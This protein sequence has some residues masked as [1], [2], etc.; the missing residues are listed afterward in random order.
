MKTQN[1]KLNKF[2]ILLFICFII[3]INSLAKIYQRLISENTESQK[4][5]SLEDEN[6]IIIASDIGHQKAEV[7]KLTKDGRVIYNN[8]T[9]SVGYTDDANLIQP[10][11]SNIYILTHHNKQNIAGQSSKEKIYSFKD[12]NTPIKTYEKQNSIYK[13][14]SSVSL[15]NGNIIVAG[16]KPKSTYGADTTS[17][18]D[19]YDPNTL[20]SG[21]GFSF[22][23]QS[24]YI[25]CYEQSEN[26]VYCVYVSYE[27]VF[28][29]KL[30]IKHILVNG[31][32]LTD[33]GDQV[34]KDFYTDFNFLKA[35]PFNE[36]ESVVL[37]QTGN[38][39]KKL[40][41]EGTRLFY[42][43]L[44]VESSPFLVTIKRYEYLFHDCL[45][46]ADPE[47][48]N[49]D[50][51]VLSKNRI[52]AACE[53]QN[54]KFR[55]FI[56]YPDRPGK[57]EI[58]EF[59][60]ENFSAA[61]VKTP[62]FAKFGQS[63]GI[64]YTQV[65]EN[66]NKKV[67]YH[68]MNYPD[69]DDYQLNPI[70]LPKGFSREIDFTGY[71]MLTNAYPKDR[72]NEEVKIRFKS[73][74]NMTVTTLDG[75]AM[76]AGTDY[77]PSLFLRFKTTQR[78]GK[79]EIEYTATRQDIYDGLIIGKTCK[80]TFNTPICLP[81]CESCTEKGTAEHHYCL[82]CNE[83]GAYYEDEDPI[84]AEA[85]L[86]KPY[87]FGK[88]HNCLACNVSCS[89]CWGPFYLDPKP[90][91]TNCKKCN[92]AE[93]Y[94]HYE[95]DER[96][97]IS[98][99]TKKYWE[100]I[101]GSAI[102]LDKS[103][104]ED[105]K[106]KWRWRHCHPN[107]DEC[108]EKG[109]NNDNKCWR[110]K[111]GLFFFCN[112]TIGNGIPGSCHS[113]CVNN[114]F[115]KTIKEDR[116]KCCPC[117]ENCKECKNE[118]I[119]DK[120]Y[121]PFLLT[122]EHDHCNLTC[123]YCYA[124]DRNLGECVNCKTRYQTP[125]YTLNKTCVDEIPFIEE[126]KR[127]H[128]ILDEKCNYLI[129]CKEGC[130]NCTP[131]YSDNCTQCNK[132]YY[133]EDFY[134]KT[135]QPEGFRCFNKTTCQGVTKYKHNEALRIG[136]VPVEENKLKV[137]LN[138]KLRND[139]YRLPENDFYCSDIKID[140]TYIDIEEYN[141]LSYCYFRCK[142]CQFWGNKYI[143]N[144]T[145]CRDG[146]YY[147][148]IKVK[149]S[150]GSIE[151]GNCYRKKHKCGIY[152]YYH[153]YDL[154]EKIGKDE[155]KCGEDCDV[156]LYNFTCVDQFPFFVYE[157]HE[158]VEYCDLTD[159]LG[160]VCQV[161]QRAGQILLINP[162]GTKDSFD[163]INS[164]VDI[165]KIIS[166][167]I[168]IYFL[169]SYDIEKN[170][171]IKDINNY[172]GNGQIYNLKESKIIV[173]NNISIELS[174]VRLEL[175]KINQ[176]LSGDTSVNQNISLVD[177]SDCQ[178]ILKSKYG[179]PSAEDL[180]LIKGDFLEKI[181][182]QYFGS[183]LYY[184]LFSTSIGA[185]LPL[186]EC[187]ENEVSALIK[188]FLNSSN[189][190]GDLQFKTSPIVD[191]GYNPFDP[192]SDFY[193]NP[194]TPFTNEDGNDVL[195]VDRSDYYNEN[196]H[197]CKDGCQFAGYNE[198]YKWFTCKCPISTDSDSG[199]QKYEEEKMPIPEGF[200]NKKSSYS[201]I[202]VFKC[203]SQA[204]SVK[205]IAKN[206]GFYCLLL[207]FISFI[208]I[209]VFYFVKDSKTLPII[210][211][212]L[213]KISQN[214]A[215]PPK[216]KDKEQ[217]EQKAG[218]DMLVK[219]PEKPYNKEVDLTYKEDEL[220]SV[221]FKIAQVQDKRSFWKYYWSLLK[222]KQLLIF[223]FYTY[224]DYNLRSVKIA[225][226]LLFISFYFAFTALFFNENIIRNSYKKQNT[227]S[228]HCIN[229][230]LSSICSLIMSFIIKFI[231]LN[232]KDKIS[233]LNENKSDDRKSKAE[234]LKR[235][236]RI[237]IIILFIISAL[238]MLLCWYY[239]TAFGAIFRN[240]QG[241]Y[242]LNVLGAFILCNLWP[243]ITSLIAPAL[244]IKSIENG[245]EC[246]YKASQIIAYF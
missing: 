42:Y 68:I 118:T 127:Y 154:A 75:K 18:I 145:A 77:L 98:N 181:S 53:T 222:L 188:S 9:L 44:K 186:K 139:S 62:V 193:N 78:T 138:C 84:A 83:K 90:P 246:Q 74:A 219:G 73:F 136:G 161:N 28:V 184:Q 12:K 71:A 117:F 93:N 187:Q 199:E 70:I 228:L 122:P 172:L 102:Y 46:V 217:D 163:F 76:V 57:E 97:C 45:Y 237:K 10:K 245:S 16:I 109:D 82:G 131:W 203:A 104:G 200:Y 113:N 23:A 134:G 112:Q 29:N 143:M 185:F 179:L 95:G 206:V 49:A 232:E 148:L 20:N 182:E 51:A 55:G 175:E 164:T 15:K 137:C 205:G 67:A 241:K 230:I 121:I 126:L 235:K 140:R 60:F 103:A 7:T 115:Y 13:K 170:T 220:N 233:I 157:T 132:D 183:K 17:E 238:L 236:M 35:I 189:L 96:T 204:F 32:I 34:I 114:G 107:C 86:K 194:C 153:D 160:E 162:F 48:N 201:N 229:I 1:K 6:I 176:L 152:P 135:P 22:T 124:E 231:S 215:N 33:K 168:F 211:D 213:G 240:S 110:C 207:C 81:Q 151:F 116:E 173:G 3:Q 38:G 63:L 59:N 225:L 178:S 56:I 239:V 72:A 65:L 69:C 40:G 169:D 212:K 150:A 88:P 101:I 36:N 11:N 108:F 5:C 216:P 87:Y 174:S 14:T 210:F 24:D 2:A 146:E 4:V 25:S 125:K 221:D 111:P 243:C 41:H 197:L 149:N 202:K 61:S 66:Y 224:T 156:C 144:C 130:H 129:G 30:K 64:F 218:Y 208:G 198:T 27:N 158:C 166:S 58:D 8:A 195:I 26:N 167:K 227:A 92:Y 54:G 80:A 141:K 155:D 31:N 209:V 133:K 226:F 191:Q 196:H 214:K 180:I 50:I 89:S 234:L 105:Q 99:G 21:T 120:C 19:I 94:F 39:G 47:Y 79:Y 119:C 128:H 106:E 242:I 223:T 171:I 190:L 159:V 192:N 142:S 177:L 244:R 165:N 85:E 37:F 123:D 43:H 100:E 91:T 52:Y 147:D